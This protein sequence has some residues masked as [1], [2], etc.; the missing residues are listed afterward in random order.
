MGAHN[1]Q[2]S[3][4]QLPRFPARKDDQE[5][6]ERFEKHDRKRN[7]LFEAI[8]LIFDAITSWH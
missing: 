1:E 4:G 5:R 6:V 8:S 7:W 3:D 2:G